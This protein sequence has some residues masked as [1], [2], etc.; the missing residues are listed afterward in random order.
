MKKGVFGKKQLTLAVMAVALC[1]AVWLNMEYSASGGGFSEE[2]EPTASYLGQAQFV[3]GQV[4]DELKETSGNVQGDYFETT[5]RERNEAREAAIDEL[6]DT[7]SDAKISDEV[8][9]AAVEKLT[10]LTTRMD[11]EASIEALLKA[12]G[13]KDVL[14]VIGDNDINITVKVEKLLE[15]EIIQIQDIATSQSGM[16]LEKVKIITVK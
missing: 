8:K 3:N 16:P 10:A 9:K 11:T 2:T 7:V 5:R 12:K 14:A 13:F 15:N 1:G 6:E 4:S